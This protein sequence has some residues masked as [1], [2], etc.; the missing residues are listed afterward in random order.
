MAAS[1][2]DLEAGD[3]LQCFLRQSVSLQDGRRPDGSAYRYVPGKPV[4][5]AQVG[6]SRFK[7]TVVSN[8]TLNHII[9][10][11]TVAMNSRR[12]AISRSKA[13]VA[14]IHYSS[15][16]RVFIYSEENF[17]PQSSLRRS[18]SYF[19]PTTNNA[20]GAKFKPYRTITAVQIPQGSPAG[21][22]NL[23]TLSGVPLAL[24]GIPIVLTP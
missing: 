8:D 15:F 13:L 6:L 10:I 23:V 12:V 14:E 24:G 3:E 20:F 22:E 18:G 5:S 9:T 2:L 11:S 1:M 16:D 17:E 4:R 7:G 21:I 19:R